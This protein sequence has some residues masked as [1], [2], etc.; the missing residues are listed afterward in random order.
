MSKIKLKSLIVSGAN[1]I[2]SKIDFGDDLTIIAGPSNTGKSYI[3]KSID[4]ILGAKNDDKHKPLDLQ[5]GY[6]TIEL[7]I[8]TDNG[9]LNLKRK[10]NS[11]IT[12]VASDNPKIESGEYLLQPNKS[13]AKTVNELLLNLIGI[14]IGI[15]LPKNNKGDSASL[16][17]RTIKQAFMLDEQS[18]DQPESIFYTSFNQ[19]L[20]FASL[21]YLFKEDD[22]S[23]YKKDSE[24][25]IIKKAKKR[26]VIEYIK[27]QRALLL[28]K[29][30]ALEKSING[31]TS[32]KSIKEQIDE[33]NNQLNEINEKIDA[34]NL[35]SKHLSSELLPIQKQLARN[36][37]TII[38]YKEL[39]TQYDTDI[40]RL[41]F[42]VENELL[43]K[44]NKKISTCP[45]CE[46]KMENH[47]HGSY[48][49]ASQ[50]ELVKL[51][52][53]LNDLE[54]TRVDLKDQIDDDESL[55]K[56]YE[57]QLY[58]I[59][60]YLKKDLIPQ[61]QKIINILSNYREKIKIEGALE[62]FKNID[63]NFEDDIKEYEKESISEFKKFDGKKLLGD[64]I[65]KSLIE[66]AKSI[67]TD[68]GYSPLDNV[69]FDYSAFDIMVNGK[70]KNT[71]GKG[72]KSFFNS[73]MM[74]SL[75]RYIDEN[76]EKNLGLY[77]FDS[78]LKGLTLSEEITDHHN[79]REGYFR[80][81]NNLNGNNQIIVMENTNNRELPKIHTNDRIKVYLF[82]QVEGKGRYGF[83][84]SVKRK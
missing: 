80:Y 48:I 69:V 66:N 31:E 21:I 10:I 5:E 49:E 68:I 12:V 7:S 78:P 25:E 2:T 19:S 77:M 16:T 17:W 42:I 54:T 71:H 51:I 9:N 14:P 33:L 62:Q 60:T 47:D 35:K 8:S 28:T 50:A 70:Q 53:N 52:N 36:K 23:D 46:S 26:A 83:L 61:R 3:Y 20:F 15:K 56:D 59:S 55:I 72:Y 81:L 40:N 11:D 45:F 76:S 18:V 84:E 44:N 73:V 75:M 63:L 4:F 1:V 6:D 82:T 27:K 79:I 67:L 57:E 24:S 13:N 64:I 41:T 43:A 37:T 38:K 22:L 30:E 32:Q 74:L 39:K 34:S 58:E 65:S 29:K